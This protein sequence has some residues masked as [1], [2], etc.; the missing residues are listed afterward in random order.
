MKSGS[1]VV[2]EYPLLCRKVQED[3]LKSW[4]ERGSHLKTEEKLLQ[5]MQKTPQY[6]WAE[7]FGESREEQ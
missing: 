4:W 3:H 1:T 6:G 7:R 5:A 2:G